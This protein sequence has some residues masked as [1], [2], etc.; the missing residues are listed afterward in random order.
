MFYAFA[1]FTMKRF[2]E[3]L[4]DDKVV[5]VAETIRHLPMT[6]RHTGVYR[7]DADDEPHWLAVAEAE[8]GTTVVFFY[9]EDDEI[10]EVYR[11][12]LGRNG[13]QPA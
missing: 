2:V 1:E 13:L 4:T 9:Q 3:R 8:P 6:Y 12:V 11:G 10:I 7:L 5:T